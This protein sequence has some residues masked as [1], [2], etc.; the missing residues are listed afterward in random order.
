ML[1]IETLYAIQGD[2]EKFVLLY[3]YPKSTLYY[4]KI[5][6]HSYCKIDQC[7]LFRTLKNTFMT[8]PE[9]QIILISPPPTKNEP[10][11]GNIKN[12]I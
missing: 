8:F 1:R 10:E 5:G 3:R 11:I 12:V 2:L 9:C 7:Y 4:P 6:Q